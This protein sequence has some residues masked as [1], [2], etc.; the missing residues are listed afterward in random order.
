L[1][2]EDFNKRN[3]TDNVKVIAL[4]QAYGEALVP[5]QKEKA[6]KQFEMVRNM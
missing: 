3:E 1:C 2:I 5:T 6:L 4:R